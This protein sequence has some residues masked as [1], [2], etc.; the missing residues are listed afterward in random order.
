MLL[1]VENSH[2]AT[3]YAAWAL[4]ASA[5]DAALAASVAKAYVNDA[6]RKVCGESIQVHGGIGF[7]WEYDLHLYFKRAK[8]LEPLYGDAA[9][10]REQIVRAL[11]A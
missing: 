7:T 10:H 3:Y 8:G 9:Y 4:D 11:S 5:E 1:E 2:S 6:A